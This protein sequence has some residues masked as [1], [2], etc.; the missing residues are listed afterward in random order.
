MSDLQEALLKAGL[1]E[2]KDL[3]QER[4]RRRKQRKGKVSSEN[5]HD[6]ATEVNR[7]KREELKHRDDERERQH[8]IQSEEQEDNIRRIIEAG[9]LDIRSGNRRFFFVDRDGYIPFIETDESAIRG[10]RRGELA[11]VENVRGN[12]RSF[13]LVNRETAILIRD[14]DSSRIRFWNM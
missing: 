11:I 9:R 13:V 8:A 12:R 2:G 5:R 4:R 7:R 1:A 3:E 10:L 6:R 14:C